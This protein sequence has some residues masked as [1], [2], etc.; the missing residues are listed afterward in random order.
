M[1]KG[2]RVQVPPRPPAL[3]LSNG[4]R[5]FIQFPNEYHINFLTIVCFL[6]WND[7]MEYKKEGRVAGERRRASS[8]G[9]GA[10]SACSPKRPGYAFSLPEQLFWGRVGASPSGFGRIEASSYASR[11]F[12]FL[13]LSLW[14]FG[15]WMVSTPFLSVEYALSGSISSGRIIERENLPQKHS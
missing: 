8:A 11:T 10:S 3:R 12:T 9:G 2:L 4:A 1:P 6:R 7:G 5:A 14:T 13:G 15:R